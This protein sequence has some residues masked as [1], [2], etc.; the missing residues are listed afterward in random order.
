L[1]FG[2]LQRNRELLLKIVNYKEG[3]QND[4]DDEKESTV[5]LG[6]P[7]PQLNLLPTARF[8]A[9]VHFIVTDRLKLGCPAAP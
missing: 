2:H 9:R 1:G 4:S 6:V 5:S 8:G 7:D 3:E